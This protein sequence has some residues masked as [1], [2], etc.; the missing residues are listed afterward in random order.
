MS[1]AVFPDTFSLPEP[2]PSAKIP[3]LFITDLKEPD[4]LNHMPIDNLKYFLKSKILINYGKET[5]LVFVNPEK[6][7][8]EEIDTLNNFQQQK[9]IVTLERILDEQKFDET[10][11]LDGFVDIKLKLED[12]ITINKA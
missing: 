11:H 3:P 4:R 7:D 6:I 12:L 10:K 8:F 9:Y 5:I 2:L 1:T